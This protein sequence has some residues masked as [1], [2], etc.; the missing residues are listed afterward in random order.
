MI[1]GNSHSYSRSAEKTIELKCCDVRPIRI[2]LGL[3]NF[4][5]FTQVPTTMP[6]LDAET[7][8]IKRARGGSVSYQ[9]D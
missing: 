2:W 8:W 4:E 9:C 1:K 5:V 7:M 6:K 3:I